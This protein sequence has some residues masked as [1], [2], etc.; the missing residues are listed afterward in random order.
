[1][2]TSLPSTK[3][4][5]SKDDAET[6]QG[7]LRHANCHS[8][9][10]QNTLSSDPV[11]LPVTP[12]VIGNTPLTGIV[13]CASSPAEK[14]HTFDLTLNIEQPFDNDQILPSNQMKQQQRTLLFNKYDTCSSPMSLQAATLPIIF[15]CA[16]SKGEIEKV[17]SKKV[18]IP[19]TI[20]IKEH[21]PAF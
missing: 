20:H 15:N 12:Q 2:Q 3:E 18:P 4:P 19:T 9:Q 5:A 14:D 13:A 11:Q 21:L 1:M 10:H 17:T 8:L 7:N 16:V 6:I